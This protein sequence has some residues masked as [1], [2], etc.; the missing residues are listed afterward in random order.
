MTQEQ[1]RTAI[2]FVEKH[3]DDLTEWNGEVP[4]LIAHPATLRDMMAA[5]GLKDGALGEGPP[6]KCQ[7]SIRGV[8]VRADENC[9]GGILRLGGR[10]KPVI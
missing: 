1:V 7:L 5:L 8:V 10:R 3:L 9:Q 6:V 2:S 4:E